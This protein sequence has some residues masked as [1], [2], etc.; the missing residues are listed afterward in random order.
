[1][2]AAGGQTVDQLEAALELAQRLGYRIR[3]ESLWGQSGGGCEIRGQKWLFIDLSLTPREQLEQVLATLRR[4]AARIAIAAAEPPRETLPPR[5]EI[6]RCAQN[7]TM[8]QQDAMTQNAASAS[9]EAS[10]DQ[11][12][13]TAPAKS[14]PGFLPS[15]RRWYRMVIGSQPKGR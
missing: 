1:M 4:E 12:V 5:G 9:T 15:W 14:S 8:T 13:N 2:Q 3:L 7:G 10:A 11:Q 6:V